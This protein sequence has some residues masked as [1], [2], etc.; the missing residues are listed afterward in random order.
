MLLPCLVTDQTSSP[1]LSDQQLEDMYLSNRITHACYQVHGR[2]LYSSLNQCEVFVLRHDIR[3]W[4]YEDS[5][6]IALE[7][8]MGIHTYSTNAGENV[9]QLDVM[10]YV[11]SGKSRTP[12]LKVVDMGAW[13]MPKRFHSKKRDLSCYLTSVGR[14]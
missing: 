5:I 8:H 14:L 6:C 12:D 4:H 3:I 2:L 1:A 10:P 9:E 11:Y 7:S 13:V